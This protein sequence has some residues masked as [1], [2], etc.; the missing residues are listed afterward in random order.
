MDY[1]KF[2]IAIPAYKKEYLS[3]AIQSCII[4]TYVNFEI[5]IVDD[6]S[7]FNLKNIVDSFR[8]CRIQYY[9]NEKN[10]GAL[11]VVANWNKCLEL[12]SGDYI[13]CMGDD[14]VLC[15]D[16]LNTYIALINKYP[17][18]GVYHA[19]TEIIDEHSNFIDIQSQR[20]EWESV[21]SLIWHRWECRKAQFIGDFLFDCDF[22]RSSGGFFYLPLAWA[23]DDITAIIAAAKKGIANTQ[24]ICFKYRVNSLTISNTG[25]TITKCEAIRLEE[26]WYDDFLRSEPEGDLDQ[27]YYLLIQKRLAEHFCKKRNHAIFRDMRKHPMHLYYWLKHAESIKVAK[28]DVIRQWIKAIV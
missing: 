2:T 19:W 28:K 25:D 6:A 9:R 13:I 17:G 18:L 16:C 12:A 21:Y 15:P 11:N 26:E 1:P 5:V 3:E 23:S 4:Q 8:D 27:K 24:K 10:V 14:D 22:L 7:P 20:P